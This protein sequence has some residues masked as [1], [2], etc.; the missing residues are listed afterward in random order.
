[1]LT[2]KILLKKVKG[3]RSA[4]KIC[5]ILMPFSTSKSRYS[6]FGKPEVSEMSTDCVVAGLRALTVALDLFKNL[7]YNNEINF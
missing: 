3:S 4:D 6:Q 7:V 1:M 5:L 2:L